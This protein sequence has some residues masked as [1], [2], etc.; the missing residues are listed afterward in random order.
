MPR[1]P[2]LD[3]VKTGKLTVPLLVFINDT[4]SERLVALGKRLGRSKSSLVREAIMALL[5]MYGNPPAEKGGN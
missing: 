1:Q 5:G 4:Q 3:I 2:S